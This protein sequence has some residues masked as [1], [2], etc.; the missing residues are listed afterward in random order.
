[1][2]EKYITVGDAEKILKISSQTIRKKIKSGEIPYYQPGKKYLLRLEDLY[3]W[4][5]NNKKK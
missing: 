2:D 5:E 1:M 4:I 3:R